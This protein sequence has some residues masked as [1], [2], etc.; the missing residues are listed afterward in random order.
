MIWI[1]IDDLDLHMNIWKANDEIDFN[2][3]CDSYI[4]EELE[5]NM[6]LYDRNI[7]IDYNGW[8]FDVIATIHVK[9][10]GSCQNVTVTVENK[11]EILDEIEDIKDLLE[12]AKGD[13]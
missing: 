12:I 1:N 6:F 4:D 9:S 7:V 2:I 5:C 10:D 11:D 13:E 8:G 3:T